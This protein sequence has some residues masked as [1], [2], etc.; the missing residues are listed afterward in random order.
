MPREGGKGLT[1]RK[2]PSKKKAGRLYLGAR[3][4]ESDSRE[5]TECVKVI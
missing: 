3:A 5:E 4:G 2:L 1:L